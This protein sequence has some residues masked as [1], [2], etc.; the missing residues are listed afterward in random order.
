MNDVVNWGPAYLNLKRVPKYSN[1]I[2]KIFVLCLPLH[3]Q[4]SPSFGRIT[5]LLQDSYSQSRL[6]GSHVQVSRF[7]AWGSHVQ[8]SGFV[9]VHLI[10]SSKLYI[11][12]YF[13]VPV[14]TSA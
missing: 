3:M 7:V 2:V 8:V 5:P 9:L 6:S 10:V 14:D 1:C 4:G 13:T 12:K 11:S